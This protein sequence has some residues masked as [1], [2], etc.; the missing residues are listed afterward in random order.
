MQLDVDQLD[1]D[2]LGSSVNAIWSDLLKPNQIDLDQVSSVNAA[3]DT[4]YS[5][6]DYHMSDITIKSLSLTVNVLVKSL[7]V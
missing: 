1:L 5:V 6:K 4:F 7:R 3:K 2:Q